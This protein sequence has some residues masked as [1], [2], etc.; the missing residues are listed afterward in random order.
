MFKKIV[1]KIGEEALFF[2][3]AGS[4]FITVI[5][6]IDMIRKPSI[7]DIL[8]EAHG[9]LFDIL[10]FG[11]I[12][13][14]Y[15]Y[16]QAIKSERIKQ[17]EDK[18]ARI[19]K[20][21]D[22]IDDF[23]GWN[24]KEAVYRIRGI[25]K[26]LNHLGIIEID[27]RNTFL[28]GAILKG[29][30]LKKSNIESANL[31]G[32]NAENGNFESASFLGSNLESIRIDKGNIKKSNLSRTI[33]IGANLSFADAT[34][35][36]ILDSN[37]SKAYLDHINLTSAD[38]ANSIL[39]DA[40]L[41]GANLLGVRLFID[42]IEAVYNLLASGYGFPEIYPA[43][44]LPTDWREKIS[45]LKKYR[46]AVQGLDTCSI[47]DV[48]AFQSQ[49]K[50]FKYLDVPEKKLEYVYWQPDPQSQLERNKYPYMVWD[51][52]IVILTESEFINGLEIN[53]EAL[54]KENWMSYNSPKWYIRHNR[55]NSNQ[56]AWIVS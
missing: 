22:E 51:D 53:E 19:T 50:Y 34:E 3:V 16:N 56:R 45:N 55:V 48:K 41:D 32:V 42:P 23:R 21:L 6:F 31:S 35:A 5:L 12:L 26:R 15:N 9:M 49:R 30:A 17:K 40:V 25:I 44:S 7:D 28:Q 38:I 36:K 39:T 37:L 8:V 11:I 33:L 13:S 1:T 24:E 14:I 20:Y 43:Y 47:Y 29:V 18:K 4:I 46:S 27:L 2:A 54:M 52:Q 10:L